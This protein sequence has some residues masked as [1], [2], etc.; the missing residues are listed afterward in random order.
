MKKTL[1]GS[2]VDAKIRSRG[3]WSPLTPYYPPNNDWYNE[4]WDDGD[5]KPLAEFMQGLRRAGDG[6][7]IN[8]AGLDLTQNTI[9][10]LGFTWNQY[11]SGT[12]YWRK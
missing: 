1:S 8:G 5:W 2:A 7:V 9:E 4:Y 6:Q 11:W 3:P 12:V 10:S